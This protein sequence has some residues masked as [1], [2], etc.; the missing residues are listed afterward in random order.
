[1]YLRCSRHRKILPEKCGK[2]PA[3]SGRLD[4]FLRCGEQREISARRCGAKKPAGV[5]QYKCDKCGWEPDDPAHPPKFCPES[6]AIPLTMAM[7]RDDPG[8][9]NRRIFC[10]RV[11]SCFWRL[12]DIVSE[13][14][15]EGDSSIQKKSAVPPGILTGVTYSH[16]SGMVA[17]ADFAITLSPEA[18]LETSYYPALDPDTAE[19]EDWY[20]PSTKENVPI[21]AAQWSDVEQI[22]LELYPL[23]EPIPENRREVKLPPGDSKSWMAGDSTSLILTWSTEDGTRSIR[24]D[25]PNDRRIHTLIALLEELADPHWT[26][27]IPRYAPPELER[28]LYGVSPGLSFPRDYSFQFDRGPS[29]VYG[30][31]APY[32]LRARFTPS[33]RKQEIWSDW[34]VSDEEWD[35][36][37]AFAEEIRLEEQPDGSSEKPACTLYYSDGEQQQKKLDQETAKQLRAYFTELALCLLDEQP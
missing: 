11:C 13:V 2:P 18:I 1:M 7:C 34:V 35:A 15:R 37:T 6:A 30:E 23:M 31:D 33:G 29:V 20:H 12:R 25:P 8:K 36:F 4:L 27:E 5:P 3:R 9:K 17:R 14:I 10:C 26:G 21:T 22:I 28:L 32:I 24:Y 16:T 19:D